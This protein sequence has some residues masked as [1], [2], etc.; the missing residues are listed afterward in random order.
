MDY[1]E[2]IEDIDELYRLGVRAVNPV[3]NNQ[4]KFGGGVRANEKVGL[5]SLGVKLIE[6]LVDKKIAIDLSHANEKTFW[7]IVNLCLKLKNEGKQP[8]VFTSHS[9]AQSL[10][11]VA[12]NLTDEQILAIKKLDGIIGVV[13]IKNFCVDIEDIC[14]PNIDFE[15]AY[16][17]HIIY[18][19]G[20]LG[21]VD[22]ISVSTDD[23]SYYYINPKYYKNINIYSHCRVKGKIKCGLEEKGFTK[24]EI[25]KILCGNFKEKILERL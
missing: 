24:L 21:G 20:L 4:N 11:N 2:N 8:I 14:N 17:E 13:S 18:I 3:W 5:T 7:G 23:L 9:N 10:C 16:I 12:R 15:K 1:I 19:K 25:D 6:K 22:N